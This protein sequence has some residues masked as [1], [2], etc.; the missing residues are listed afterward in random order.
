MKE[1]KKVLLGTGMAVALLCACAPQQTESSITASG[2]N[3]SDYVDTVR[4]KATQLYTLKNANGM[5]VCITNFGGR[6]VSMMVPDKDNVMRDVV[7]GF[8]KV[9]NYIDSINTPSDFGASIGRYANR[10]NQG[11]IVVDGDTIQLP[12]NNFGHCLHGG[13]QGWQYQVYDANQPN[14]TTLQLV[15]ISPDGEACFPGDVT[16]QVTYTLL[17]DNALDIKY[18]AVTTK[19]TV[20]NMTNHCYFNLSGNPAQP[21]N[22]HIVYLNADSF[23]PVDSTFMT[24]GEI[25]PVAGTPMD[26]TEARSIGRDITKFEDEQIKN[27]NGYDHNWCLNTAGDDTQVA[28]R[29]ECPS[30]GIV[31][32]VYTNEPGIQMYSGNFLDG[33]CTGKNGIAYQQHAGMCL[34]TQKYPDSPNKPG[35][36]S[37]YLSPE[38]SYYSHCVYKFGVNK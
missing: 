29:V 5:E 27:A 15:M 12:V 23:T 11:R 37:A 34:E 4:G 30:T 14:D 6:V 18:N 17:P 24:T 1:A 33:T 38:D 10:I 22:D 35:W 26:F 28:A 16:A 2:L 8:D 32:E 21:I 19:N 25:R 31:L 13:P 36:P 7:L 20:F 3:P 9:A